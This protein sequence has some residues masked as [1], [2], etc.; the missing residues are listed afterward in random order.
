[1]A[2]LVPLTPGAAANATVVA[3]RSAS[4][5]IGARR[6]CV[7]EI[8]FFMFVALMAALLV[9][10]LDFGHKPTEVLGIV[11]QVIKIGG[12]EVIRSRWDVG[13]VENHVERLS[14]T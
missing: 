11:R 6:C 2:K 14:T 8:A 7:F 5:T 9:G 13:A 10:D 12:V 4:T 3:S 1:M